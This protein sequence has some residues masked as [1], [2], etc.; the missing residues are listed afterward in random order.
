MTVVRKKVPS[1]E[2]AMAENR[3]LGIDP[4]TKTGWAFIASTSSAVGLINFPKLR[5]MERV[6]AIRQATRELILSH[7][8]QLVV[9]EG[10]GYANAH[11]LAMLVEIG[12]NIRNLCWQ[13]GVP[14]IEV[15]PNSL[16]LYATESGNAK[17]DQMLLACYKRWG[18]EFKD[19]NIADAYLL[20]NMGVRMLTGQKVG[21]ETAKMAGAFKKLDM[22][23]Q[24]CAALPMFRALLPHLKLC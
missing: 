18:V 2:M 13:M 3:V 11:S 10:Y 17:K 4:S 21:N 20:C 9:I 14:Y 19:D 7:L 23:K 6:E 8:P 15:P 1:A 5:G 24:S 16:K 12:A 22:D